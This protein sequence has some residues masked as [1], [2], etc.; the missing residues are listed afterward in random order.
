MTSKC[1]DKFFTSLESFD[2]DFAAILVDKFSSQTNTSF[3][4]SISFS[5]LFAFQKLV[6]ILRLPKSSCCEQ[7][8]L[9]NKNAMIRAASS[10]KLVKLT[11]ELVLANFCFFDKFAGFSENCF[12]LCNSNAVLSE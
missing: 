10:C 1:I 8:G 11:F 3:F 5:K 12:S 4:S 2:L 9:S 7:L 6:C